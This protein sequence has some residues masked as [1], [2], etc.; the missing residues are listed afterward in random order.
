MPRRGIEGLRRLERLTITVGG[1]RISEKFSSFDH[2]HLGTWSR[3]ALGRCPIA[4]EG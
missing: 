2:K 1:G 3:R 4:A